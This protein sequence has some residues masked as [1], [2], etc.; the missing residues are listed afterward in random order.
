MEA[1]DYFPI[2]VLWNPRVPQNIVRDSTRNCGINKNV[3]IPLRIQIYIS[4]PQ[5]FLSSNWQYW[6]N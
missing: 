2:M 5:E 3:V 4:I 1:V 6:S